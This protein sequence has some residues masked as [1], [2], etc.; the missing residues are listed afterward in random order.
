V[1]CYLV[2]LEKGRWIVLPHRNNVQH[3]ETDVIVL[4]CGLACSPVLLGGLVAS[5]GRVWFGTLMTRAHTVGGRFQE[6]TL[7]V[8]QSMSGS[9]SCCCG[10]PNPMAVLVN[11]LV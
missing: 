6:T 5:N 2:S 8:H 11:F 9:K 3:Q 7:S 10:E 4:E 1:C